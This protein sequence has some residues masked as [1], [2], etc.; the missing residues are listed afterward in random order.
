MSEIHPSV[1]AQ[2]VQAR[3]KAKASVKLNHRKAGRA[4]MTRAI[5]AGAAAV[6]LLLVG[7]FGLMAWELALPLLILVAV[8][9]S[10]WLGAWLQFSFAEGGLLDVIK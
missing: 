4:L 7:G 2:N 6:L 5:A 9:L 10:I 8:W 3:R 1:E